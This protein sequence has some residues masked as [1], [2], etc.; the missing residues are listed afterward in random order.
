METERTLF[1]GVSCPGGMLYFR[2]QIQMVAILP[3]FWVKMLQN[4]ALLML[5]TAAQ[6]DNSVRSSVTTEE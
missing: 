3:K 1:S 2:G 4:K 5:I 6:P